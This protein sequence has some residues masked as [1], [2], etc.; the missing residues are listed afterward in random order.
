MPKMTK[1]AFKTEPY[2]LYDKLEVGKYSGES[3]LDVIRMNSRYV[4]W[5]LENIKG[6]QLDE[7]AQ[8][9]MYICEAD[10][11]DEPCWL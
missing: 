5:L 3:L 6:F 1:P 10:N 7:E 4:R 9:F 2:S 11:H 8:R